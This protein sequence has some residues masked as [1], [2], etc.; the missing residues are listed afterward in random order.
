MV[1]LSS[2]S[3]KKHDMVSAQNILNGLNKAIQ[4]V[5]DEPSVISP[6]ILATRIQNSSLKSHPNAK[7]YSDLSIE[8]SFRPPIP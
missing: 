7:I 6:K 1:D 4:L 2:G 5:D 8:L 3:Q